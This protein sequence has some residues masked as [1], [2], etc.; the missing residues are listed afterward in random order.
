MGQV[1]RER[2]NNDN[3]QLAENEVYNS[4]WSPTEHESLAYNLQFQKN[5]IAENLGEAVKNWRSENWLW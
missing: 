1:D 5:N 4:I 3:L 2:S